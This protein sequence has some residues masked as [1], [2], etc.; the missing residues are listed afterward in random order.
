MQKKTEDIFYLSYIF[1]IDARMSDPEIILRDTVVLN[2]K[3]D[4]E[5][6][7]E[8]KRL[9]KQYK[10]EYRYKKIEIR[11]YKIE[12]MNLFTIKKENKNEKQ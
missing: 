4:R 9:E 2:A 1:T 5:R 11:T 10:K 6:D 8:I 12:Q 3:T 7:R